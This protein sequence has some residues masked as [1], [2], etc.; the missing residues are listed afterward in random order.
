MDQ[1]EGSGGTE[2]NILTGRR[3]DW[4]WT[5][6][7]PVH[8]VCPGVLPDGTIT[9]LAMPRLDA[10]R[11]AVQDYFD[12]TWTLTEVLFA[13]LPGE[14]AFKTLPSHKLRHPLIFYY[15][16]VAA[17][18]VNKLRVAGVVDKSLN[19]FIEEFFQTGVDEMSWDDLSA[20]SLGWPDVTEVTDYRRQVY[21]LVSQVIADH[22]EVGKEV[23]PAPG[24]DASAAEERYWRHPLWSLFLGF[25]HERIHLE[26]SSVLVRELPLEW[27]R[28]PEEW[29]SY[30]DSATVVREAEGE[31]KE[32]S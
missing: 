20:P 14:D 6:K 29:R 18:Y 8:G 5:G 3:G 22:P 31:L 25:E 28:M 26:T 11:E 12:N 30:H 17:L 19:P 16:H 27:L 4:W 24:A 15:G 2:D 9:S 7:A 21:E 10:G 32:A 23:A 13:S 1:K